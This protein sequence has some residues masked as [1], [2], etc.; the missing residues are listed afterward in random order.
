MPTPAAD[1][2]RGSPRRAGSGTLPAEG[3]S[4][5][6]PAEGADDEDASPEEAQGGASLPLENARLRA[7]LAAYIAL[8]A[9]REVAGG[10]SGSRPAA[11]P[12]R[13]DSGVSPARCCPFTHARGRL[14]SRS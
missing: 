13:P 8:E 5:A 7:E 14:F 4:E 9:A 3:G 11:G 12:A 1:P 2:S 10:G 6:A